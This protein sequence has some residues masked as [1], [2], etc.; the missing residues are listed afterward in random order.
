VVFVPGKA[1][2]PADGWPVVMM[3]HG[4]GGSTKNV[5][6]STGWSEL[7]E[8][9][10][11]V[12]VFP[13]GTP[14]DENHPESFLSNPQ[15]WNSGAEG[16]LSSGHGSATDKNVDDVGFLA[17]LLDRV[18][19]ELKVNPKKIFVAGHSNGASMAYRFSME[20]PDLVAAVGVVAGHFLIETRPLQEPVS[21]IQIVGDQDPFTPMA[22]G[23]AG[24]L[25]RTVR[26][27][28]ALD[29]PRRWASLLGLS[30]EAN[31]V[32][33]DDKLK[34]FLWGPGKNG[35]EVRSIV[36][37]GHGH[38]Y[39]SPKDTFH[40]RLLFGPTVHSLDATETMWKFFSD[41]PKR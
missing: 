5:I 13:N 38:A 8:R 6:E 33:D 9:G 35:V 36:I 1:Q 14:K 30:P 29:S 4:A 18:R 39:P 37:K 17:E 10:G 41:H 26:V 27:P 20:H 23:E 22:G 12:S 28:P 31:T 40:P 24:V 25:N 32:Q 34:M 7:G 19:H 21:L 11:F 2:I 15:T 16:N 3:L